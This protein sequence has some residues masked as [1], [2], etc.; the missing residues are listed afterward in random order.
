MIH[1][2]IEPAQRH[3]LGFNNQQQLFQK[4]FEFAVFFKIYSLIN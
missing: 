2:V 3:S 4:F 1:P